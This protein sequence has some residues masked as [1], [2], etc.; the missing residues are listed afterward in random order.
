MIETF[1]GTLCFTIPYTIRILCEFDYFLSIASAEIEI[2][3]SRMKTHVNRSLNDVALLTFFTL[4]VKWFHFNEVAPFSN[5]M[6][7]GI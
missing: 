7:L 1:G 3:N 4:L 2:K 6:V 5:I